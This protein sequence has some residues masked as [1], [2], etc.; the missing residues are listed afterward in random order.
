M[1]TWYLLKKAYSLSRLCKLRNLEWTVSP[2][3]NLNSPM[4]RTI[5][6]RIQL[7]VHSNTIQ[8]KLLHLLMD[9]KISDLLIVFRRKKMLNWR[10]Q[11][12]QT[13]MI[14]GVCNPSPITTI[15]H[16]H[17]CWLRTR[18]VLMWSTC[19][20]CSPEW[21]SRIAYTAGTFSAPAWWTSR[22]ILALTLWLCLTLNSSQDWLTLT[23]VSEKIPQ[24]LRNSQLI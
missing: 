9:L 20:L 23:A 7:R 24:Q 3:L 11:T 10:L 14:T 1:N 17:T 18:N 22:L 4:K 6:W 15:K 21:S 13:T 16:S 2:S 19:A 12:S 5:S 8:T